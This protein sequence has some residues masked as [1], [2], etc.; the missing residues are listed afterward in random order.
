[1]KAVFI[2]R[3][4]TLGG[5]DQIEYPGQFT[6]YPGVLES[7]LKLKDHGCLLFS[8]TNQPGISMGRSSV[9]AF[10]K[11][12]EGFGFDGIF[13]CPHHPEAGCE[14]R[15][16]APGMINN[17]CHDYR[18]NPGDCI[19]IG[20]RLK[21]IEAGQRAGCE[22]I[23]VLTGGGKSAVHELQVSNHIRKPGYIAEDLNDAIRRL[24]K[25]S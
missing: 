10:E 9:K 20:D 13:L 4:G 7:L 23:L 14:C 19:V 21:D 3:D 15:K 22:Q 2:D 12:L 8:F 5:S 24:I 16:P 11:E 25:D 1:M 17:A 6:L 18:L